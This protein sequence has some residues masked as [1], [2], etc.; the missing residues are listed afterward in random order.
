MRHR[1]DSFVEK[2]R[3]TAA[4]HAM[5]EAS[6]VV[7]AVSGGADSMAMLYALAGLG[8]RD[9]VV[10]HFDH[11]LRGEASRE[12]ARFV[13]AE[14]ARLGL[15]FALGSAEV[16]E[17]AA[18]RGAN[19]EATARDL[20][21]AFLE[22]TAVARGAGWVATG[23]TATDQAE[24]VLM[25]L[26]RGA[27]PDGLAGVAAVRALGDR[28]VRLAR[29]LLDA[30]RE[31]TVAWCRERGIDYRVDATNLDTALA[32]IRA[33]EELLPGLERL[34]P[35]ATTNLARAAALAA[36]DRAYF[37]AR[38]AELFAAWDAGPE[39]P[40]A[41]PAA[42]VAALPAALR[43]RALREAVRRARGDLARV[44]FEHVEAL[45]RLLEPGA[46]GRRAELPRGV[47]ARRDG[48]ALVVEKR[49]HE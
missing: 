6:P 48:P 24:T 5:L 12:D 15:A 10:A 33:R 9:L 30:T 39:G 36:D 21:Y 2:V 13:E 14:A 32:R 34:S 25:R 3:A 26:A 28:G 45:E 37:A 1:P 49:G 42:E 18:R 35:G 20:R 7:A 40:V 43:R 44:T 23:H 22:E 16:G 17:E 47:R 19:L 27:G 4:R 46:A 29:P 11:R 31:E 41:L 8:R 38:V